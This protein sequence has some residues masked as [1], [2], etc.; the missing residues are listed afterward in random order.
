MN[1]FGWFRK[2]TPPPV[3]TP[4]RAAAAEPAPTIADPAAGTVSRA[5]SPAT[6]RQLL[7]DAVAAGDDERLE[8][9]CQEHRHF[10]LSHGAGWL[11]VPESFRSSPDASRWYEEGLRAL[12]RF[13]HEREGMSS[14][15]ASAD[16]A[17]GS[18]AG[19]QSLTS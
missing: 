2:A 5:P 16:T 14:Q 19:R 15:P 4:D 17:S 18:S 3:V 11:Q 8:A 7:F 1:L 10:I 6:V 12:A 13:C 9:L